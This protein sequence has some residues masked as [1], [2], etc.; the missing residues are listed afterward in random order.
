MDL[1]EGIEKYDGLIRLIE[2]GRK[3]EVFEGFSDLRSAMG[4][5]SLR[6]LVC[7]LCARS[8]GRGKWVGSR[9]KLV[10]IADCP[11]HGTLKFVITA[12]HDGNGF[13]A[14]RRVSAASEEMIA[15]YDRK[16]TAVK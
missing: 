14:S 7:P 10:T 15:S 5:K 9:E 11:E 1:A 16:L 13:S 6:R 3:R 12:F 4:D 8:L 2:L